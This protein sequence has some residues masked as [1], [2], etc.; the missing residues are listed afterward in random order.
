MTFGGVVHNVS[1]NLAQLTDNIHLQCVV[2]ND[3][4]GRDLLSQLQLADI[5]IRSSFILEN[6]TTAKKLNA[7]EK[8]S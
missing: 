2:G 1:K 5:N 3:S 6:K 8:I 7:V 4:E